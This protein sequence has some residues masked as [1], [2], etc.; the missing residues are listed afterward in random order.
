MIDLFLAAPSVDAYA[1]TGDRV[2]ATTAAVVALTSVVL[3]VVAVAR[4]R[5]RPAVVALVAGSV[6]LIAGLFVIATADGGPGTGN[7]IVG[8]FVAVPL[9]LAAVVLGSLASTRSAR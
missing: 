1:V 6:G 7:G 8:G 3:G 5:R 4:T 9:G 2:L